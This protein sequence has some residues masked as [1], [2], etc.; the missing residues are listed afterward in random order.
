MRTVFT[1]FKDSK[2]I[3]TSAVL[4]SPALIPSLINALFQLFANVHY[5]KIKSPSLIKLI[6]EILILGIQAVKNS[7]YFPQF[8][9]CKQ[10]LLHGCILK[11]LG[12]SPIDCNTF[13]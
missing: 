8:L 1:Q 2:M 10:A 11:V 13:Y 3:K 6:E 12:F 7:F 4:G 5:H 9:E